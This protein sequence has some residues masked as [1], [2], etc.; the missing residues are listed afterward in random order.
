MLKIFCA[1]VACFSTQAYAE[2]ALNLY[3]GYQNKNNYEMKVVY[4][5]ADALV[6]GGKVDGRVVAPTDEDIVA[7]SGL[8]LMTY[9]QNSWAACYTGDVEE[10]AAL[11]SGSIAGSTT[12]VVP[13]TCPSGRTVKE[14][15]LISYTAPGLVPG[16]FISSCSVRCTEFPVPV[17]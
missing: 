13:A 7:Y 12:E 8:P 15:E 10:V 1:L 16:Q 3:K 4:S 2:S 11:F 9:F 17:E 5:N 14:T 6:K